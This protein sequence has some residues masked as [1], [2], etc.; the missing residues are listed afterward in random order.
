MCLVGTLGTENHDRLKQYFS[1]IRKRRRVLEF[2]LVGD[3]NLPGINW[4]QENSSNTIEQ[5]F[6]TT[7]SDLSLQQLVKEPTHYRGNVLDLVLSDKPEHI[8]DL[9]I[10]S[11]HSLCG[12]DHY[13]I[14]FNLEINAKKKKPAKR[15]IFNFKKAN[16]VN[17]NHTFR[18]IDW[19][20]F[21]RNCSAETAWAKFKNKFFEVCNSNIPKITI[22]NEFQPPWF[23]SEVFHLCR[24][25]ERLHK[26]WKGTGSSEKYIQFS[27]ARADY[28]NLVDSKMEEN[29]VDSENINLINKT[30]WSHVKSKSNSHRIPE[31]VSY[32]DRV[33]SDPQGQ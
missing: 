5:L 25:K 17:I 15:K 20:S 1:V 11:E 21:F 30:F 9:N 29:F 2:V 3:F 8:S 16:W 32:G 27:R 26:D 13:A 31:A 23:D 28:K 14:T 19:D 22:S 24:K 12:S 7:F 18:S 33:R 4:D 10:D 6:V